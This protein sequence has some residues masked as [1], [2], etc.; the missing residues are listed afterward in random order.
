MELESY[1]EL[2]RYINDSHLDDPKAFNSTW[3]ILLSFLTPKK[4]LST[5]PLTLKKQ[6]EVIQSFPDLSANLKMVILALLQKGQWVENYGK[7][8][9]VTSTEDIRLKSSLATMCRNMN[10]TLPGGHLIP[11]LVTQLPYLC[12]WDHIQDAEVVQATLDRITSSY[13][14]FVPMVLNQPET[15]VCHLLLHIIQQNNR[16]ASS[17][18][19]MSFLISNTPDQIM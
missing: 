10:Y 3:D 2:H 14:S 7:D 5:K 18:E 9:V 13:E 16:A 8:I 11:V 4:I 6:E 1:K 19:F 15:S 17:F 12:T